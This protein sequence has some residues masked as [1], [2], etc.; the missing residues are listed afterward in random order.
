MTILRTKKRRS[1]G[2]ELDVEVY[3]WR[4]QD[5][6]G[7]EMCRGCGQE[8]EIANHAENCK[9]FE[10]RIGRKMEG[11]W[12]DRRRTSRNNKDNRRRTEDRQ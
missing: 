6:R 11:W 12:T 5:G 7:G 9:E 3:I 2:R 10:Q 1:Y 8:K 4:G